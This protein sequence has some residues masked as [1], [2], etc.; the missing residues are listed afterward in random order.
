MV[1]GVLKKGRGFF[2]HG[3]KMGRKDDNAV[4]I[5]ISNS[6]PM[7]RSS[8]AYFAC[9]GFI[10]NVKIRCLVPLDSISSSTL[11]VMEASPCPAFNKL[12]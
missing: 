12:V 6:A 9:Q 11:P 8:S 10:I 2:E 4:E 7:V 3:E 1:D 5:F